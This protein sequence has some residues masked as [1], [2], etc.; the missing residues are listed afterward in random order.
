MTLPFIWR[1]FR[2][3]LLVGIALGVILFNVFQDARKISRETSATTTRIEKRQI[4]AIKS[5]AKN[6]ADL[7]VLSRTI[8]AATAKRYTSDDAELDRAIINA[9]IESLEK[10]KAYLRE[11]IDRLEHLK[12]TTKP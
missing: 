5:I 11:K 7:L 6:Q 9:K 12:L 1:N 3:E 2:Y 4:E 8:N 10:D